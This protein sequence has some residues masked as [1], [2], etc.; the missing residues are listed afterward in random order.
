MIIM[1]NSPAKNPKMKR[2]NGL[3]PLLISCSAILYIVFPFATLTFAITGREKH[4]DEGAALFGVRV[5][6]F[7]MQDFSLLLLRTRVLTLSYAAY[8]QR[9]N[10]AQLL[11]WLPVHDRLACFAQ[12]ECHSLACCVTNLNAA[13]KM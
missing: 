2:A 5:Y 3:S 8:M 9:D 4:S 13:A 10:L 6:G 7:V 12:W 11:V 1:P